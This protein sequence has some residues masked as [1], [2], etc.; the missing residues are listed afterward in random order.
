MNNSRKY[1]VALAAVLLMHGCGGDKDTAMVIDLL[2]DARIKLAPDRRTVVFDVRGELKGTTLALTGEIHSAALKEQLLRYLKEHREYTIIDSLTVLPSPELGDRVYGLATQS[3]INMR[4]TPDHG[5]ELGSQALLG[6][7]LKILKQSRGWSYVQ[8]PDE[9]LGWVDDGLH[10]MDGEQFRLWM[11]R[12]KVIV[13]TEFGFVRSGREAGSQRVSDVV[14]GNILALRADAGT[15][16]EVAYPD[17]RTGYLPKDDAEPYGQWLA[18]STDTPGAIVSTAMRFLGIPYFWGGTSA[19]ALDCSGFTKTVFFLNGV[20]LP[21]DASQQAAVGAPVEVGNDF[22]GIEAGDLLF[23]GTKATPERRER[24]TH[25][26]ISLGR[27]RFIHEGGDVRI[28]SLDPGDPDYSES[29]ADSFL[30]ARR[31][32]GVGEEHGVRRLRHIP[33]Y[34]AHENQ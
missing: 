24:V 4:T 12:P 22:S 7:P 27:G 20:L 3:V 17:G 26:G 31:I 33:E 16:Y 11:E 28:N 15:V 13:T 23:F 5:A 19:K 9:Y 10:Q 8:T 1:L 25:V 34:A 21:R 30:R 6:T 29:R 32:I 18:N 14:A 2:R